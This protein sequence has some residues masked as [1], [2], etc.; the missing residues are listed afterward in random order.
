MCP[1]PLSV[2][3]GTMLPLHNQLGLSMFTALGKGNYGNTQE[4]KIPPALSSL[5]KELIFPRDWVSLEPGTVG[6]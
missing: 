5:K 1:V 2:S 4:N 6:P 3:P